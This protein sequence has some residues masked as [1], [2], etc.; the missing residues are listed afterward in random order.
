MRKTAFVIIA[1][2]L[3]AVVAVAGCVSTPAEGEATQSPVGQWM[4]NGEYFVSFNPD[5]TVLAVAGNTYKGTWE[6][7]ESGIVIKLDPV[8]KMAVSEEEATF[9]GALTSATTCKVNENGS[10]MTIDSIIFKPANIG[11][12][13]TEDRITLT[14][15]GDLTYN[16]MSAANSFFGTVAFTETGFEFIA[17]GITMALG[18]EEEMAAEKAFLEA[19]NATKDYTVVDGKLTLVDAEGKVLV[20]LTATPV[21]IWNAENATLE[22]ENGNATIT[23]EEGNTYKAAYEIS[24]NTIVLKDITQMTKMP[25]TEEEKA[26]FETLESAGNT[27]KAGQFLT[28]EDK[29]GKVVQFFS[30]A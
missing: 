17:G 2:V 6:V 3:A 20:T 4:N 5:G 19:L 28:V 16:G 27:L 24:E 13:E 12:W 15:N 29:D 1:I 9:I 18:T 30:R 11:T 10:M 14:I 8:T 22:L 25:Q 23:F 21:G 26:F 7:T